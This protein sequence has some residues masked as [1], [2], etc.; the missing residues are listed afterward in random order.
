LCLPSKTA[1]Q[2]FLKESLATFCA[3]GRTIVFCA[4]RVG[5]DEL[6][7]TILKSNSNS[8]NSAGLLQLRT[9]HGDKHPTDRQAA[10]KAFSKGKVRLLIATD[11]AGRGL[12]VPDIA[13]VINYDPAKNW[14]THVHRIGRAGRLSSTNTTED[15]QQEGSS[16]T[17]LL[18]S[19][20]EFARTLIQAYEREGRAVPEEVQQLVARAASS[21][22][23]KNKYPGRTQSGF[24]FSSASSSS[25]TT[26]GD[27]SYYGPPATKKSRW[28]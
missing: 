23:N 18:P 24:G 7:D 26:A 5:V 28:S 25:E 17:L 10:L 27:T 13:T 6:A 8:S 2:D 3:V 15:K 14:D 12:D 20:K 16:Y 4:T 19:D 21:N 22:H 1:K 9:L 11:V